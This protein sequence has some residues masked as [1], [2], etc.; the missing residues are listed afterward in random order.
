MAEAVQISLMYVLCLFSFISTLVDLPCL[1]LSFIGSYKCW[2]IHMYV[3][4]LCGWWLL[5]LGARVNNI[6]LVYLFV[7]TYCF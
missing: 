1:C 3:S 4:V 5:T 7:R 2:S 6:I